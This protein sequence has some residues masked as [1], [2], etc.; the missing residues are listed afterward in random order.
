VSTDTR[1]GDDERRRRGGDAESVGSILARVMHDVRPA[2][3][4]R[5]D[6]VA[7]AWTRVAGVE[8]AQ[9]T[10]PA[11]LRQ[12][13]LTVEVRS[14][15]LLHELRSFRRD[16]LLERLLAAEPSGR[17]IGLRFRLGVF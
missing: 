4:R 10:R 3:R 2:R 15:S 1:P 7:E 16:E 5:R 9:E 6:R 11:T 17:V 8:L 12:G 14:A 13:V